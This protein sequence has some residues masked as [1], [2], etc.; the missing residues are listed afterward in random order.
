MTSH[1][2][3]L[4]DM[5]DLEVGEVSKEGELL[6]SYNNVQLSGTKYMDN[7]YGNWFNADILIEFNVD[8]DCI[9]QIRVN[10]H[11]SEELDKMLDEVIS[12][13]YYQRVLGVCRKENAYS[14]DDPEKALEELLED[15]GDQCVLC[16]DCETIVM[17]QGLIDYISS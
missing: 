16:G 17:L 14:D 11:S 7:G 13:C 15:H 1:L 4:I 12:K 2:E 10:V 9:E 5:F 8:D 6:F 3:E